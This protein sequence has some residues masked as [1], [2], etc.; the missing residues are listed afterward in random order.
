MPTGSAVLRSGA[1]VGDDVWVTGTL[2]DAAYALSLLQAHINSSN[3]S[4]PSIIDKDVHASDL[5]AVRARLEQP[6]PRVALG[7]ALRESGLVHSMLDVSDGMA[8]DLPHILRASQVSAQI[9]CTAL[10][11]S[12]TLR[13]LPI[14]RAWPL[15]LTGGDDYELCLTAPATEAARATLAALAE[16]HATALTRVGTITPMNPA[17]QIQWLCDESAAQ[18][19]AV[20]ALAH[21]SGYNHF[22]QSEAAPSC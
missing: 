7:R 19:A 2:G 18:R 1:Q 4:S 20:S 17:A 21:T 15:A 12:S 3:P 14:E 10:P 22:A 9:D 13:R 5:M 16:K 8:G 6:T 11:L